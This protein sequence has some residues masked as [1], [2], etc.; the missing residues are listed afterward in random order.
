MPK[1]S[2]FALLQSVSALAAAGLCLLEALGLAGAEAGAGRLTGPLIEL[3]LAGGV[4]LLICA[5]LLLARWPVTRLLT[6]VAALLCLPLL[7]YRVAPFSLAWLTDAPPSVTPTRFFSLDPLAI[8]G[9]A[10]LI[11]VTVMSLRGQV[12]A[13]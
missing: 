5:A 12:S 2:R 13:P 4:G 1:R 7:L 11:V 9:L 8:A 3:C 6:P 10:A